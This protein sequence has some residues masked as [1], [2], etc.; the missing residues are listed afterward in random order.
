MLTQMDVFSRLE[1]NVRSYC[2]HFPAVFASAQGC[3]MTTN[4]GRRY[5]D[6][7]C[8]AGSLNYGH[9]DPVIMDRVIEYIRNS[10][11]VHS[12][13]LHTAAKADFLQVFN[14]TILAP[15]HLDY[16]V[17]FPGPTG[18]NAV[19]AALKLA[20]K[21]TGRSGIAAFVGGYHG[22]TL[23]SRA[24]KTSPTARAAAGVPL[25]HVSFLPY[26][27]DPG[28]TMDSMDHIETLL[29]RMAWE[30]NCPAAAL[31]EIV[32]GE[33]G[34]SSVTAGWI[35]RLANLCK[36]LGMLTIVD[37]IQAGCGRTG[38]F[39][40]FE[41]LGIAPDIV[42]LSKSLSG[43]GAPFSIVL[44]RPELDVWQ[45]G[46]HNGTF[47]GNNLA[48]VGA[49][50]AIQH[51]WSDGVFSAG[52]QVRSDLIRDCLSK[53]ASSLPAGAARIKGRGLLIGI[54]FNDPTIATAVSERAFEHGLIVETCGRYHHVLKLLPP[55]NISLEDLQLAL[56][57]I[58]E[59][60]LETASSRL[61]LAS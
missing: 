21:V 39:F 33:G 17:Q 45:P 50:A 2:R 18:T 31:I 3:W 51:Y 16:K 40:S 13:D 61:K 20:R 29:R 41:E 58:T 34:L 54:K 60:V 43:F 9:N 30:G 53:V 8:G 26:Q 4:D 35:R 22:M 59:A 49:T 23:G 32:Q 15:R 27:G 10:G 46:E 38:T 47:R 11:V 19:E 14:D 56:D 1:S 36:E 6:L 48:F 25:D 5:L 55:L 28:A 12:L 7:L 24:E 57:I 44:M 37:D 52:I 42:V